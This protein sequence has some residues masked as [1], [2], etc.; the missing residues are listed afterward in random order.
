MDLKDI[1]VSQSKSSEGVWF[2]VDSETSFLIARMFN[3][4]FNRVFDK[5]SKAYRQGVHRFGG[6]EEQAVELMT[7]VY[8]ETI[9]LDWKGLKR[10]GKEVPY[11]KEEAKRIFEDQRLVALKQAIIE[12]SQNMAN[13]RDEEI[14]DTGKK[15]GDILS[16]KPSGATK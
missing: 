5:E 9:L 6:D 7:S 14:S 3:P 16:G 13:Y 1:S 11:S 8:A 10:D 4:E 15:S 2:D 12:F